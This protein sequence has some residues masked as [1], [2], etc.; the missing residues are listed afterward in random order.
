[1]VLDRTHY[2]LAT[3][4]K[5]ILHDVFN[6]NRL[7][8]C[9]VRTYSETK[10]ITNVD[11]LKDVLKQ[12]ENNVVN[13][14]FDSDVIFHDENDNIL[15]VITSNDVLCITSTEPIIWHSYVEHSSHNKGLALPF[16][17][18]KQQIARQF[19]ILNETPQE[20]MFI[21]R[22]RYKHGQL[23]VLVSIPKASNSILSS[24]MLAVMPTQEIG[25]L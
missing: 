13:M 17:P 3:L 16:P 24:G 11:K 18:D 7:K 4:K 2:I 23:Q 21:Y 15:P 10:N 1:M 8:S 20:N 5:Q 22:V 6:F 19:N 9:F 14:M 25:L 12:N